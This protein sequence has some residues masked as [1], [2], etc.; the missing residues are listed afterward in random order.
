MK[1]VY[2]AYSCSPN[3]GSE[4]KVA[5]NVI[6]ESAKFNILFVFTKEESRLSIEEFRRNNPEKVKNIEFFYVDIPSFYKKIFKGF[7]YSARLNIW[8]KRALPEVNKI[9]NAENISIIHQITPIEFRSVGKYGAFPNTKFVCGPI[10]GGEY[11]PNCLKRYSRNYRHIEI[12]RSLTNTY[13]KLLYRFNGRLQDC[14]EIMFANRET[15]DYLK[16]KGKVVT[17]IGIGS[18]QIVTPK[19]KKNGD[20]V[21]FLVAGRLIYRKGHKFLLDVLKSIETKK[22]YKLLIVG[23]GP[24]KIELERMC[25]KS[26]TL[27]EH[28]EFLGN[29]SYGEMKGIYHKAD[30]LVLPSIRETTGSVIFEALENGLPVVTIDMFG[31]GL[32]INDNIGWKYSGETE[33]EIKNSL[34]YALVECIEHPEVIEKKRTNIP[35]ELKKCEWKEK[36]RLYEAIYKKLLSDK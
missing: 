6:L 27:L 21:F 23:D 14:D 16:Y 10:G 26:R 2:I 32:I 25:A 13:Y 30:V 9:V 28:V 29:V 4:D 17:E 36:Y 33:E 11:V 22:P 19:N 8:N 35:N 20:M 7:L 12:I 15:A 3:L 24:Y 31:G 34:K 5:W 1:I 18:H